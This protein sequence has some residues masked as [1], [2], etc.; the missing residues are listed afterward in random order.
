MEIFTAYA[1][2][3]FAFIVIAVFIVLW[4]MV[5]QLGDIMVSGTEKISAW[6]GRRRRGL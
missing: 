6:V 1:T 2:L 5:M 3:Q 4:R